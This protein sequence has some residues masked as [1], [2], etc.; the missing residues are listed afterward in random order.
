MFLGSVWSHA[1]G[2][3]TAARAHLRG[4]AAI[5]FL[6]IFCFAQPRSPECRTSEE[7]TKQQERTL[8]MFSGPAL[9][10]TRVRHAICSQVLAARNKNNPMKNSL[11]WIHLARRASLSLNS[12]HFTQPGAL[13]WPYYVIGAWP[14]EV[15]G[16]SM[17]VTKSMDVR[18][19]KC[20]LSPFYMQR[21]I[22]DHLLV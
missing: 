20:V 19:H 18:L 16:C 9:L 14:W 1:V 6:F 21:K 10:A 12:S 22:L 3:Y 15:G 7:L 5:A 17:L 11:L 4:W 13:G 2:V 8:P